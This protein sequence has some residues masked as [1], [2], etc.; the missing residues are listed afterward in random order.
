MTILCATRFTE[1]SSAASRVAAALA[2]THRQTLWLVHVVPTR[3]IPSMGV[4]L[5]SAADAALE[6]E[7]TAL[8]QSGIDVQ[9][10][11]LQGRLEDTIARFAESKKASLLVVGDSTRSISGPLGGTLDKL[12]YALTVPLLVV[13]DPR[14]F[15]AWATGKAPLKVMLA[16]D[17][18]SSSAI[19][20]DWIIRLAKFGDLDLVAASIWW[21]REEYERRNLA[22][23]DP[24]DGHRALAQTLSA[25]LDAA[26]VNLPK[27]VKVR[28]HL[29]PGKQGI[30][31][32]LVEIANAVQADLVVLGTHR[33]R[34]LG[35]LW[36]VSHHILS[37]A[38]MSVACV[39]AG[40]T[41]PDLSV[42]RPFTTGVAATDFSEAG[43]R[44]I[45]CGLSAVGNG[46][47]HVIHVS[48]EAMPQDKQTALLKR[49]VTVLP[50]EAERRAKVLVHVLE[51]DVAQQL[52]QAADRL[53]AD[54]LCLG[55]HRDVVAKGSVASQVLAHAA[56]PVL[57]APP[58]KA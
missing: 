2:R 26:L 14:P 19:A 18:T 34:A 7:A 31:E 50:P 46:T 23:P 27:N 35:R 1:E 53:G 5:E 24:E 11:V 38:P 10:A 37:L 45:T 21:P 15:E 43:N 17:H 54:V 56:R 4:K 52:T 16:V 30:A 8:R 3:L 47:L 9:T 20:R 6:A 22:W 55:A 51:G 12:A 13:R 49:L 36:S 42:A 40:V 32:E 29:E 58:V 39:P 28:K 44:A 25:E 41:V 33:R 57:F 48:A